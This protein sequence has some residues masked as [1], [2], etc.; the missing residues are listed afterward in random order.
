MRLIDV[1]DSFVRN[2]AQ[3][4]SEA[5]FLPT[6]QCAWRS[7]VR[8]SAQTRAGVGGRYTPVPLR[9]I[10]RSM[11]PILRVALD[12]PLDRLFDYLAPHGEALAAGS[13][14]LVPF[15]RRKVVGIV[16]DHADASELAP[17]RLKAAIRGLDEK[18]LLDVELLASL[19]RAARYY[20]HPLGEVLA[21]ALPA[22][23][24]SPRALPKPGT[25]AL[26][27]TPAGVQARDDPARRKGTRLFA[28]IDLLA[29]ASHTTAQLDAAL[30]GWRTSARAAIAR[31]WI[32]R[33]ASS[34]GSARA[35]VAA[36]PLNA[37]Q[38]A[39]AEAIVAAR[40]FTPFV[41]DGVTG[42]GKT[43]VYLAAIEACLARGEQALVLLPE[44]ALTPQALR[45]FR[46]RLGI[47]IAT[48]HS[49]LGEIER[50]R[51]WLAAARGEARVVLGTRSAVFVPLP[52]AGIVVVDEEHDTS[53]KQ[54]DGF[55]YHARD[56][57]VLRAQALGVPIVLGSATPSLET[58][59]NVASGRYRALRLS[60][61]AGE[62]RPPALRVVDLRG[63]PLRHGLAPATLD[64]IAASIA[65]GEQALIFKN[66][67]GYAPVLMCHDCGWSA[68]CPH[69]E[70]ALTLHQANR[71]LSC[72][73]C[74]YGEPVPRACPHCSGL[75]LN[76]LGQGTERLEE[77]L[78]AHFP[79]V[80]IVRIDRDTTRGRRARDALLD[81]LPDEGARILVGTQMLAKGHDLPHLTLVVVVGVD[82]GLHSVDFRASE[83]LGQLV[84]QVAGRAGRAERP[85]TVILQTH[86][87]EHPL[88]R[89]LL[90]GGYRA[91]SAEMLDER[92]VAGL[93]PFTQFSLLRAEAG[94]PAKL[95]AF[96][97]VAASAIDDTR[98]L[99]HGPMPAPMPR[100]GGVLRAQI[101]IEAAERAAMQDFLARWIAPLR[102]RPEGKP[103]R[104]SIDVDPVDLY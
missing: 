48:L 29:G 47:D 41:L 22:A 13:R 33:V 62:A 17:D 75:A 100:R 88:L 31:G 64:A 98:I 1:S 69:C 73:H 70:R 58:L 67:R 65:R 50:A 2:H 55:R 37:E 45:R 30:P 53:Y 40:G 99:A 28:L 24:R 94:D 16:V 90:N 59:A 21:T 54:Q 52:R 80:P 72:H 49:G 84:V 3:A 23:L 101:L 81:H 5:S 104:W 68:Q 6:M 103:V 89:I 35:P 57:A 71:R 82:E 61:R 43:E 42:S 56:L 86:D 93:P 92:R 38:R 7:I 85:G 76:P 79:D 63:Q 83:R 87:P 96:L 25:N 15:G 77:T 95:D 18:P 74:G 51:A 14:V 9:A 32:E 12:V 46:E 27:L 91:L 78:R 19:R 8:A 36:P 97:A 20:Q 4:S 26:A 39:A 11:N 66:R 44:I 34:G 102:E 60:H 10:A